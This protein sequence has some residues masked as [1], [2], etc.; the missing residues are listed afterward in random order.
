MKLFPELREAVR[1]STD[2]ICSNLL[3]STLTTLGI[4]IGVVT[5][6]LMAT[7][8]QALQ[9]AFE[10]AVSFMGSDVLYV[11]N[12]PW[13]PGSDEEWQVIRKRPKITLA[14]ARALE[15]TLAD[16][17]AI[18][19]SA[20]YMVDLI[21]YKDR[22]TSMV[23]LVG[24]NEQFAVTSGITLSDGRFLTKAEAYANRDLCVIGADVADKLFNG[25]SPLGERIRVGGEQL[26][27]VGVMEKRGT[28]L[29]R[30]SLDNQIVIPV[31][32]MVTGYQWDPSCTIHVKAADPARLPDLREELRGAMRKI[33]RV[34]PGHKDDFSINQ[35]EQLMNQTREVST[36]I[37]T[38]GF[39]LTG[40]SLFV[41]GIGI[42][43]IMFVSVTERTSEIG[44]RKALGAR[45]R[46]ILLQFLM[47]AAGIGLLGAIAAVV[48]AAS[49][50]QI[51]RIYLPKTTLSPAVILLALTI[52][53]MTGI[54]S[55]FLPAWRAARM[56][57]V[58]ALRNE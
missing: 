31:G 35:Q 37:A 13:F 7:A 25:V 38:T 11:S 26:E 14:Q 5:V 12:R 15:R 24:T 58:D 49:L 9:T 19:P 33:R 39:F 3:R 10:D 8:L 54:V 52:A 23:M 4:V 55:G 29:G 27:V 36:V 46:T 2:A 34:P 16:V 17:R 44:L 32:K 22:S 48:V 51:A 30:M 57:P 21:R 47:E 20:S 45:R 18:A 56:N 28:A 43:N 50:V 42:M 40:L 1:I 41:G 6:T 53:L